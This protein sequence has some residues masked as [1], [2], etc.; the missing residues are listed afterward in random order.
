MQADSSKKNLPTLQ[1]YLEICWE[2]YRNWK[3]GSKTFDFRYKD[4]EIYVQGQTL[5][6]KI[7]EL[8]SII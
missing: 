1:G 4:L 5:S 8:L 6:R 3:N 2:N 7:F